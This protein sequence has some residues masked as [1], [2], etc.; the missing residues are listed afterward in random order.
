MS[1]IL[2]EVKRRAL[3]S[4]RSY[5]WEDI[6]KLREEDEKKQYAHEAVRPF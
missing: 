5:S 1:K 4:G 6:K 2:E 3:E